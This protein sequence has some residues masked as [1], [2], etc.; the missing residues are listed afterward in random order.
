MSN[1]IKKEIIE[2]GKR[3][4]EKDMSAAA[5]GN[6]SLKEGKNI[7]I[8]RHGVCLGFLAEEDVLKIDLKGNVLEGKG[9]ISAETPMHLALYKNLD[10]NCIIHSHPVYAN[11]YFAVQDKFRPVTFEAQLILGNVTV[12]K[13]NTPTVTESGPVVEAL[14]IQNIAVLKN[15]GVVAIGSSLA[16]AF[17]LTELLEDSVKTATVAKIWGNAN[18]PAGQAG[19]CADEKTQAMPDSQQKFKL[20]SLEHIKE[21]VRLINQDSDIARQ[22][23]DLDLTCT[24]AIK[25]DETNQSYKMKLEKGKV[26]EL[27]ASSDAE[28]IISGKKEIWKAIFDRRLDP[29]AAT[30]QKK[31]KLQGDFAKLSKWYAPFYKIFDIWKKVSIE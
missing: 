3:L 18:Q 29:F 5:A 10:T 19:M 9:G 24:L 22:G 8:T 15:H 11:G 25:M 16:E 21:I 13:Q 27:T 4:Y 6:I 1:K 12:I 28:F 30:M 20:F 17:S 23:A 31:L 14:K 7:F 26:V 2:I